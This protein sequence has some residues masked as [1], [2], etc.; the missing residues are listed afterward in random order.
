MIHATALGLTAAN[1]LILCFSWQI[2][3]FSHNYHFSIKLKLP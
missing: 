3:V 1:T 2:A